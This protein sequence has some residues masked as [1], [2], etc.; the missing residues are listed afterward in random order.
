MST[1]YFECKNE[2]KEALAKKVFEIIKDHYFETVEPPVGTSR[3]AENDE[4]YITR[5]TQ[6]MN[7]M[8]Y[9]TSDSDEGI[10]VEFDTTEDAGFAIAENVYKTSNGYRDYGLLNV[11]LVL[12]KIVKE[13]PDVEF[14]AD[15]YVQDK[16]YEEECTYD[17]DGT[18]LS[19]NGLEGGFCEC[20]VCE[21]E[22]PE[23]ECVLENGEWM[24]R[25]CYN[26]LHGI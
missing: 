3:E 12:D 25:N 19:K 23:E 4:T 16:N 8:L 14:H 24:C 10:V 5:L 7:D 2:T 26:R 1:I 18:Y 11:G 17:Y 21:E 15:V 6:L 13:F 22:F 9:K 20:V